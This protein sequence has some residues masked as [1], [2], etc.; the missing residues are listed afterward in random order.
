VAIGT[1]LFQIVITGSVGTLIYALADRV[2]LLMA[3]IMLATAS[4]GSQIGVAATILVE[5]ASIRLMFGLTVLGGCVAVAL[6]QASES[7]PGLEYLSDLAAV[8]LLGVA[9]GMCMLISAMLLASKVRRRQT[10][11]RHARMDRPP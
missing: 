4:V 10:S 8:L 2:D 1:G 9:V 11:P 6:K 7:G 5:G 3:L